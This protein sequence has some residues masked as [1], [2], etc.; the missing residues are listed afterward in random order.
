MDKHMIEFHNSFAF[1]KGAD[2]GYICVQCERKKKKSEGFSR[3]GKKFTCSDCIAR[4][5]KVEQM[6]PQQWARLNI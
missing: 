1:A 6:S 5:A 2:D 4:N 3:L